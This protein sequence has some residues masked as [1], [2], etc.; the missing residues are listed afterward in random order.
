MKINKDIIQT[1]KLENFYHILHD[2]HYCEHYILS[3]FKESKYKHSTMLIGMFP[4]FSMIYYSAKNFFAYNKVSILSKD[5]NILNDFENSVLDEMRSADIKLYKDKNSW[6]NNEKHIDELINKD[7]Y[8]CLDFINNHVCSESHLKFYKQVNLDY[9]VNKVGELLAEKVL[10]T[11][12]FP[13][14]YFLNLKELSFEFPIETKHISK[15]ISGENIALLDVLS[16]LNFYNEFL[17]F[18]KI[19]SFV[20]FKIKYV[21][22]V[23]SFS[24][25]KRL[26]TKIENKILNNKFDNF[27]DKGNAIIKNSIYTL[28]VHGN[29]F[30]YE[31]LKESELK[32]IRS[33]DLN[34][35]LYTQII[36]S[37]SGTNFNAFS[38]NVQI[39][40]NQLIEILE[41]FITN[42]VF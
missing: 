23:N 24:S 31:D 3:Y 20:D 29:W 36:E 7:L 41:D 25:V 9:N 26:I 38:D 35:E 39:L 22:F 13:K 8:L 34:K 18:N 15:K 5:K 30:Q 10:I 1:I 14:E 19:D 17:R 27:V 21:L 28:C 4:Y 6:N 2:I 12:R 16:S 40:I 32:L 42:I 11:L 33:L 37:L